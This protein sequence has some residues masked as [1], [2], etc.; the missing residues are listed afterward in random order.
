MRLRKQSVFTALSVITILVSAR[1][2]PDSS[3]TAVL[4]DRTAFNEAWTGEYYTE[5]SLNE[6]SSFR[7]FAEK[8]KY[9]L[10]SPE[11]LKKTE[12]FDIDEAGNAVA[13]VEASGDEETDQTPLPEP[14]PTPTFSFPGSF[15]PANPIPRP[16]RFPF[17]LPAMIVSPRPSASPVA[18]APVNTKPQA[19]YYYNRGI[20]QNA[21]TLPTDGE[22]FVKVFRDRDEKTGGRGWGTRKLISVIQ[23]IAA[24][25]RTH[26]PGRER[27]QIADMARQKGGK[28]SHASHQNGLE[29]DIIYIRR[30]RK[31]QPAFGGFGKNGFAEQFVVPTVTGSRTVKLKSGKKRIVQT[32]AL[33]ISANFDLEANFE[34]LLMVDRLTTVK[35]YFVDKVIIRELIRWADLKSRSNEPEVQSMLMKLDPEK[36]HADHFHLR[37]MCQDGD[38]KCVSENAPGRSSGHKRSHHK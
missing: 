4:V 10:E 5:N 21:S 3:S 23:A 14:S 28:M 18:P 17:P 19:L 6:D 15:F 27:L 9:Y 7:T 25:F 33:G 1:A 13:V 8:K 12:L 31:E 26:F 16:F 22:G 11:V 34:L 38:L 36:S 2:M 37:L 20:L 24:E 35:K 29:A 32:S 30:N